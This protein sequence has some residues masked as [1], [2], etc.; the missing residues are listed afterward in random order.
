MLAKTQLSVRKMLIEGIVV[1]EQQEVALERLEVVLEQL[2][3]KI[4][5]S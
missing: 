4:N 2:D 1:L 5:Q 3:Q